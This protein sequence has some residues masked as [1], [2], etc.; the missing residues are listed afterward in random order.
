VIVAVILTAVG[1]SAAMAFALTAHFKCNLLLLRIEANERAH[2]RYDAVQTTVE[3][4][5]MNKYVNETISE[6]E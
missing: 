6:N 2:E 5:M 1:A 4:M 3:E